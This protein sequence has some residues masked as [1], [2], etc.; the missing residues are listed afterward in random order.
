MGPEL[1]GRRTRDGGAGCMSPAAFP[2]EGGFDLSIFTRQNLLLPRT[3]TTA[4]G[5]R[6]S[7][8]FD[9]GLFRPA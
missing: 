7:H 1:G 3:D 4:D 2:M 9:F 6:C 8:A 5:G